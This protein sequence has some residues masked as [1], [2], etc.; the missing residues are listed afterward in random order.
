M[1]RVYPLEQT[2]IFYGHFACQI[3]GALS[4]GVLLYTQ[5]LSMIYN[6]DIWHVLIFL[7]SQMQRILEINDVNNLAC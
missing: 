4:R 7:V 1:N 3:I 6:I 2:L 5:Y